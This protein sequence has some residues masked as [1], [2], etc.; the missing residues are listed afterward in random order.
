MGGSIIFIECSTIR[1]DEKKGSFKC[2]GNL[3]KTMEEST[4]IAYSYCRS[5]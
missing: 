2:T 4:E 5:L 1:N 3:G